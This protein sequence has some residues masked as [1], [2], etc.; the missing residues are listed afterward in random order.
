M[1]RAPLLDALRTL[2]VAYRKTVVIAE[3]MANVALR[4]RSGAQSVFDGVR[5]RARVGVARVREKAARARDSV[6]VAAAAV[7]KPFWFGYTVSVTCVSRV[8]TA[9]WGLQAAIVVCHRCWKWAQRVR[10][11]AFRQVCQSAY[12]SGAYGVL[13]YLQTWWYG[14]QEWF[15]HILFVPFLLAGASSVVWATWL[16]VMLSCVLPTRG[17]RVALW[18]EFFRHFVI[19]WFL[20]YVSQWCVPGW[21]CWHCGEMHDS[22]Q[23]YIP[24]REE[25]GTWCCRAA[26]Q[27]V[28]DP[29][30]FDPWYRRVYTWWTRP[31]RESFPVSLVV[32]FDGKVSQA[33]SREVGRRLAEKRRTVA[34]KMLRKARGGEY[35]GEFGDHEDDEVASHPVMFRASALSGTATMGSPDVAPPGYAS[36]T[37]WQKLSEH[38]QVMTAS[39]ASAIVFRKSVDV[40]V[41]VAQDV[42]GADDRE[43]KTLAGALLATEGHVVR[44]LSDQVSSLVV[45]C[46]ARGNLSPLWEP[47]PLDLATAV[48]GVKAQARLLHVAGDGCLPV[49]SDTYNQMLQA[50]KVER[51]KGRD[52][53]PGLVTGFYEADA[54]YRMAMAS[55]EARRTGFKPLIVNLIGPPGTGKSTLLQRM[56]ATVVDEV[57]GVDAAVDVNQLIDKI[58]LDDK[59][60]STATPLTII[61]QLDDPVVMRGDTGEEDKATLCKLVWSVAT[62]D[63]RP[64]LR[65]VAEEKGTMLINYVFVG[66]ASNQLFSGAL[67]K[68]FADPTAFARR[69]QVMCL[70][71]EDYNAPH[72]IDETQFTGPA[73]FDKMLEGRVLRHGVVTV[74]GQEYQYQWGPDIK[75]GPAIRAYVKT[76]ISTQMARLAALAV[77]KNMICRDCWSAPCCEDCKKNNVR[78]SGAV[79]RAPASVPVADVDD[80]GRGVLSLVVSAVHD[81]SGSEFVPPPAVPLHRAALLAFVVTLLLW[82]LG[83]WVFPLWVAFELVVRWPVGPAA[84]AASGVSAWVTCALWDVAAW[85]ARV[86][87][88]GASFLVMLARWR[89]RGDPPWVG[90]Y[91]RERVGAIPRWVAM[92]VVAGAVGAWLYRRRQARVPASEPVARIDVSDVQRMEQQ[93]DALGKSAECLGGRV[94]E[95]DELKV[96]D[97]V[98]FAGLGDEVDV[99]LSTRV[100]VRTVDPLALGAKSKTATWA[101]LR[102]SMDQRCMVISAQAEGETDVIFGVASMFDHGLLLTCAHNLPEA[103]SWSLTYAFQGETVT[104]FFEGNVHKGY[105]GPGWSRRDDLLVLAVP[106]LR[107]AMRVN[108]Y[109]ANYTPRDLLGLK[110]HVVLGRTGVVSSGTLIEFGAV[111]GHYTLAGFCVERGMSGSPVWVDV[112]GHPTFIGVVARSAPAGASEPAV[113]VLP[114]TA[115]RVAAM[116]AETGVVTIKTA[117]PAV[118]EGWR[119]SPEVHD[120]SVVMFEGTRGLFVGA[121]TNLPRQRIAW[122]PFPVRPATAPNLWAARDVGKLVY[123]T[124]GTRTGCAVVGKAAGRDVV[125]YDGF[126]ATRAALGRTQRVQAWHGSLLS[127]A[128]SLTA[129][130]LAA[131]SDLRGWTVPLTFHEALNGVAGRLSPINLKSGAGPNWPGKVGAYVTRNDAG[132]L[133]A[134]AAFRA[135]SDEMLADWTAGVARDFV[136]K[137]STKAET[138]KMSKDVARNI[139]VFDAPTNVALKRVFGRL[140]AALG[141]AGYRNG[142]LVM[143]N[144]VSPEFGKYMGTLHSESARVLDLDKAAMDW[145]YNSLVWELL[146]RLMQELA[147]RDP[148]HVR[149]PLHEAALA[150][151]QV[152]LLLVGRYLYYVRIGLGSG[153]WV[154]TLVNTLTELTLLVATLVFASAEVGFRLDTSVLRRVLRPAI[155]G[156]DDCSQVVAKFVE[157]IKLRPG[158]YLRVTE[159][160]GFTT[161]AGDKTKLGVEFAG[162][163]GLRFLKRLLDPVTTGGRV[164]SLQ[165]SLPVDSILKALYVREAGDYLPTAGAATI[166]N[167]WREAWLLPDGERA[168]VQAEIRQVADGFERLHPGVPIALMGEEQFLSQWR[169]GD[170]VTWDSA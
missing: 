102:G 86:W 65:A 41:K 20:N 130:Y 9:M 57:C 42:F 80:A 131:T 158:V 26:V 18:W 48:A 152:G 45:D 116:V 169:A 157:S 93:L 75:G 56:F 8:R 25:L 30:V 40:T 62:G 3:T 63:Q 148:H 51:A 24:Y 151:L 21:C 97:E 96:L 94:A 10:R 139:F 118:P 44:G 36:Q 134:T 115:A 54:A 76:Y 99:D 35:F 59:F 120:K 117:G 79:K 19:M 31:V 98:D 119:V 34:R 122:E 107:S 109:L 142:L 164:G 73:S 29:G 66:W 162:K 27:R 60:D 38:V 167:A 92:L 64:A 90:A 143:C 106:A 2:G 145:S 140:F 37:R 74:V 121:V 11:V 14:G 28:R 71:W 15:L 22:F 32:K 50:M 105:S 144:A 43:A 82:W 126:C 103:H 156:D 4:A 95:I 67:P 1:V 17:F 6:A 68:D 5:R 110:A 83:W 150:S 85:V 77:D 7:E 146:T 161:T 114:T 52:V 69:V 70:D 49:L 13:R 123:D 112:G 101:Q 46:W 108:G 113:F 163:A 160:M 78:G 133:E 47:A 141:A 111:T 147:G 170:F 155:V 100:R 104:R 132:V 159:P 137:V 124:G 154:T 138:R 136:G 58:S 89:A 16:L 135:A 153:W 128:V 81:L 53:S 149:G 91:V 127:E 125:W 39:V 168:W 55:R 72:V 88:G 129:D 165:L 12:E 33:R 166:V 61:G 23:D 87:P 84:P